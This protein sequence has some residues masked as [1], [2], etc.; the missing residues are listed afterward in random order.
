[1]KKIKTLNKK[2]I[3][4]LLLVA[5]LLVLAG[6]YA[7]YKKTHS[8]VKAPPGNPGVNF[9]PPTEADKQETEA[10]KQEIL[11]KQQ[12][13]E[14]TTAPKGSDGKLAVTPVIS[15]A[16][17]IESNIE[18]G[19]FVPGVN[20]TGGVCKVT[21]TKGSETITKQTQGHYDATSTTCEGFVIARSEFHTAGTWQVVVNY[22][23]ATA[24]GMSQ[25]RTV[26]VK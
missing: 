8:T 16:E 23:S 22:S 9:N 20:E 10:H 25:A 12:N 14:T 24:S 7:W 21:L 17:Q 1:M 11:K 5:A 3:I 26:E 13:N 4:L 18:V 15:Y 19:A 6:G 2:S